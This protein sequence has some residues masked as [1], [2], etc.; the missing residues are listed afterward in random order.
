MAQ[1]HQQ[2]A[3][4]RRRVIALHAVQVGIVA[5]EQSGHD[6]GNGM[7]SIVFRILSA[8][9]GIVVLD[10]I[11]EDAGEEIV[12]LGKSLF[13]REV[14][15]LI[16]QSTGKWCTLRRVGDKRS[17]RFKKRYLGVCR[18]LCREY[19]GVLLCNVR[20]RG[21]EDG[22]EVALPLLIPQVGNQVIRFEHGHI[23]RNGCQQEHPLIVG[24][25]PESRFPF[26]FAI[27]FPGNVAFG[28][29]HLIA[30]LVVQKL[31]QEYL[32]DDLILVAVVT[33]TVCLAGSFQPIYEFQGFFFYI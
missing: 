11:L 5:H 3:S 28:V 31:I 30:E 1:C 12:I 16:H 2:R 14:D 4:A 8:S 18:G 15:K 27:Q 13:K 7:R 24:E 29:L 32:S 17:E 23:G 10:E 22:V 19:V 20:H 26:F 33:H 21:I 9:C 6:C 25:L